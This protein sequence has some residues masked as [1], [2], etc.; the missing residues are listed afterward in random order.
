MWDEQETD[1]ELVKF[2]LF[3]ANQNGNISS[4]HKKI[5]ELKQ[6][7]RSKRELLTN[8]TKEVVEIFR[9]IYSKENPI[10]TLPANLGEFCQCTS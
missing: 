7:Y 8:P 6:S 9:K 10:P 2:F 5:E 4:F 3:Q 1:V